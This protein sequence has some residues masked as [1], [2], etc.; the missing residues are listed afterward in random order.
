MLCVREFRGKV[1]LKLSQQKRMLSDIDM[2]V[3]S[4]NHTPLK[5]KPYLFI[6]VFKKIFI[7]SG[8]ES[9]K[10]QKC[11]NTFTPISKTHVLSMSRLEQ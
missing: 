10:V 5:A 3:M 2:I 4:L 7:L 1:M 9:M 6:S 11:A 8:V